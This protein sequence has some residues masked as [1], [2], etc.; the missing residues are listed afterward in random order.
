MSFHKLIVIVIKN[1]IL[2]EKN[3]DFIFRQNRTALLHTVLTLWGPCGQD[4]TSNWTRT[5]SWF[6]AKLCWSTVGQ[7]LVNCCQGGEL[8]KP[9]CHKNKKQRETESCW[10]RALG[11]SFFHSCQDISSVFNKT[12]TDFTLSIHST[13]NIAFAK[14]FVYF[15]L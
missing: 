8:L 10:W 15:Y 2:R 5:K 6:K 7:F 9:D 1:R 13:N 4:F 11:M 3:W 12:G 14:H